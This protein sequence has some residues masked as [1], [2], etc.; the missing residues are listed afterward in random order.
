[1]SELQ[2]RYGGTSHDRPGAATGT[3]PWLRHTRAGHDGAGVDFK[4]RVIEALGAAPLAQQAR[5]AGFRLNGALW[6][7]YGFDADTAGY[8]Q[9]LRAWLARAQEGD[10]LMMHPAMPAKAVAPSVKPGTDEIADAR[11]V[12]YTVLREKGGEML[13]QA[14][15]Q[16]GRMAGIPIC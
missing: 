5:A 14:G 12:E 2:R 7:V 10:V 4:Q 15:V 1:L 9:R 11:V 13:A 8:A 3:L 6:G 16:A